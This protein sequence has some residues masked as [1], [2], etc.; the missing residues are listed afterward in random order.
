[1]FPFAV[2][3]M[4]CI[5]GLIVSTLA[6]IILFVVLF[7]ILKWRK[8][9]NPYQSSLWISGILSI[10]LLCISTIF[11]LD[12]SFEGPPSPRNE[13][14]MQDVIGKY[15]FTDTSFIELQEADYVESR[16]TLDCHLIL[17]EDQTFIAY[18]MPDLIWRYGGAEKSFHSLSGQWELNRYGIRLY[19]DYI[20]GQRSE[21]EIG[22]TFYG[23][24]PPFKIYHMLGELHWLVYTK[25]Q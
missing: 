8:S 18:D 11:I 14:L 12:K 13:P 5:P 23:E 20:D 19:V 15:E 25:S 24:E 7:F 21:K 9:E 17:K 6:F 3:I 4:A 10:I 22:L 2:G 1:M 16:D